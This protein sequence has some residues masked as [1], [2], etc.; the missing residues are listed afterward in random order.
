MSQPTSSKPYLIRA[1]YEWCVDNGFTPH[2]L[3]IVDGQTRVPKE[4]VRDGKIV[5]NVGALATDKLRMTNDH[6]EFLARFGGA[7]RELY[8]PIHAV[9]AI[10]ARENGQGMSFEV[11]M[12]LPGGEVAAPQDVPHAGALQPV[13]SNESG[14]PA[15]DSPDPAPRPPAPI[16]GKPGLRRVK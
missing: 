16:G 2:L 1:L 3:V 9:A 10:Y 6:I 11:T 5:L 7:A 14:R 8:V 13:P 12:S 4:H 15:D